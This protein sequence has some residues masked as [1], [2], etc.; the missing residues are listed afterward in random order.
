MK[1]NDY[2]SLILDL[3]VHHLKY[4]SQI[5]DDE[6]DSVRVL[7]VQGSLQILKHIP[8]A[9]EDISNLVRGC[10]GDKSWRVRFMLAEQLENLFE[11]FGSGVDVGGF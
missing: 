1:T 3:C 5:K 9:R 7:L 6:S 11:E 8:E 4:P 2:E 10:I